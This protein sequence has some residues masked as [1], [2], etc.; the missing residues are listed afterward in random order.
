MQFEALNISFTSV[1]PEILLTGLA[2]VVL[3]LDFFL[4]KKS[5]YILGYLSA[6]GLAAL[7]P[8]VLVSVD[9][10]PS[11]GGTVI[12]DRFAAFFN[13]IFIVAGI[14]ATLISMDYLKKEN[15]QRGEYYYIILF[16]ILG[17]MVM[18]SS[19][20]LLNVYVG[21]E[22][23]ALSFY[24]LVAQKYKE[25]KSVEGALKYFVLGALSSGILLYGLSF[26][27]GFGGTTS[28]NMIAQHAASGQARNPFLLLAIVLITGGF[29]FKVALFPFHLWAPDVYEGAPIPITAL[30]SVGSKAAAFAV[31]LRIFLVALP[32]FQP[33]WSKLMWLL[34][35]A[36]MLFGSVVAIAQNSIIRMMAYSSIA[37]AG[38]IL[39]GMLV[40]SQSGVSGMLYYLLAYT[41]M[42]IG[43][44]AVV[45]LVVKSDGKGEKIADYRG[46]ASQ[47][48]LLAFFMALYLLA[49][50]GVPPT[51]G[52][53]AKFFILA[54]A[55][56]AKYYWLATIGVMA[57]AV[58]LFFYAKII[59]YMYM[60]EPEKPLEI[61]TTGLVGKAVL[62][63]AAAGTVIPGIY[64]A[65]F[66]DMAV[67]AIK[68][69]LN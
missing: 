8:I 68:P 19:N 10:N 4:R 42:N 47:N 57:T 28:L 62:L 55:I 61:T 63:I 54:S 44:F 35:A 69:L 16:A 30:L 27:F 66:M 5:K 32:E 29:A 46:L 1:M 45:T 21:L 7:L 37:H 31:F 14:L 48:P 60:K 17:M 25:K 56:E 59:F 20:D 52:F 3:L 23:M 6:A 39:I 67:K 58:A 24:I 22:L 9:A 15:I 38:I 34:S 2:L 12:A 40:A 65:P 11:F 49:L 64:P 51:A 36:T 53:A 43:V 18:A 26:A 50:A 41:F 13:I 33:E